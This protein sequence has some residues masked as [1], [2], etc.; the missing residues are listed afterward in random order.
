MDTTE[1]VGYVASA[2]V[3][4]SL[5]MTSVVR[6][7]V[8][9]LVG[10]AVFVT[11]GVLIESVPIVIT[12]IAIAIINV[13]FLRNELGGHRTLGATE[14]PVDAPFLVDF[15]QYHLADI[16]RFQPAFEIPEP[17]GD[18]V[19]M[20]LMRDGLPA[21]AW[22]GRVDGRDLH[23][24]LDHVTKPYR[25]SQL[26]TWLYGKGVGVFR[27]LGVERLVTAP[28]AEAHRTYLERMGFRRDGDRYVL[29]LS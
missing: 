7:R 3:V 28:G 10:S 2:L 11:Y 24:L 25:D 22:I 13:W 21:G 23:V 14:V 20:L 26:S 17:S 5:A 16:R 19:A 9:S 27:R 1:L 29:D 15:L 8:I 12:N 4:L 6:L 18:L